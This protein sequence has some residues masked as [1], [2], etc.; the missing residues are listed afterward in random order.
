MAD[1]FNFHGQTTFINRPKDTVIRDFQNTYVSSAG[2]DSRELLE[3][4]EALVSIILDSDDLA[5][6]DKED[7]VQAVHEIAD[8]VATKSKSR[9]T[10]KGTLQALKDVVSGAADIAGPAIEIVSS[11][12]T[13]VKG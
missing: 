11:I 10:L 1:Q 13:L 9:I 7:A 4:L 5:A 2:D 6:S 12:L 3:R 8:G